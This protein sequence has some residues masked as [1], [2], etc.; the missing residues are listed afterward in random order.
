MSENMGEYGG[1]QKFAFDLGNFALSKGF[2]I[3]LVS[4]KE[5]GLLVSTRFLDA[6]CSLNRRDLAKDKIRTKLPNN[7]FKTLLFSVASSFELIRVCRHRRLSVI[8]AQDV[9]FSGFTGVIVHRMFKIPLM[10]H[11]HGPSPY[12]VEFNSEATIIQKFLMRALARVVLREAT[13][14]LPT[15]K[16]TKSL[17]LSFSNKAAYFCIPTPIPTKEFPNKGKKTFDSQLARRTL[18]FG[19]IGRLSKQKNLQLLLNALASVPVQL[20]T[21]IS[22]IIVGDGSERNFLEHEAIRLGINGK[23]FFIGNVLEEKKLELLEL[24][25]VFILPSIYEGCPISLLEAMSSGKAIITS[26]IPSIRQIVRNNKEAILVNPYSVDELRDAM[27]KLSNDPQLILKLG[28][29]A[30]K[31]AKMY[32]INRVFSRLLKIYE[33]LLES[34]QNK[35]PDNLKEDDSPC[36]IVAS[37]MERE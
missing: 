10:V 23:V 12:F 36:L 37:E 35:C 8:H 24:F 17:L 22:L 19:F 4:S 28:E 34:N 20:S 26:N 5:E 25:D 18:V 6:G 31:R 2:K 29:N 9:F 13:L 32:D 3:L 21:N 14:I 27:I 7:P 16:H 11:V 33:I 30:T 1:I 15:D